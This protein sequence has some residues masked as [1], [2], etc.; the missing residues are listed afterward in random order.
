LAL[1]G[2][3]KAPERGSLQISGVYGDIVRENLKTQ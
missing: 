2:K 3:K 1:K